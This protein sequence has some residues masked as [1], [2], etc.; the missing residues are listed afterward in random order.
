[1]ASNS[2]PFTSIEELEINGKAITKLKVE[3]LKEELLARGLEKAGLKKEL[4]ERLGKVNN[5]V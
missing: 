2:E 1:M 3:E 4:L 5:L